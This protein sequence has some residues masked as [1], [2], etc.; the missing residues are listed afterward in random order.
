MEKKEWAAPFTVTALMNRDE[1]K[2]RDMTPA[3]LWAFLAARRK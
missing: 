1:G 2:K 3:V